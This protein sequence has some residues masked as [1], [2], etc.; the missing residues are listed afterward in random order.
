MIRKNKWLTGTAPDQPWSAAGREALESRCALVWHYLVQAAKPGE[1][2][3]DDVHQL[4][5]WARRAVTAFDAY[6]DLVPRRKGAWLRKQLKRLRRAAGEARDLDVLAERLA[7]GAAKRPASRTLAELD[8][9]RRKARRPIRRLWRRLKRKGY[10]DRVAAVLERL[11]YRG[12]GPEPAFGRGAR[13]SLRRIS[14]QFCRRAAGNLAEPLELHAFRIAGKRL[15]YALELF[16][17]AFG[18]EVRDELYPQVEDLQELLGKIN[19]CA[20]AIERLEG[21]SRSADDAEHRGELVRLV[22]SERSALRRAR[23]RFDNWWTAARRVEIERRLQALRAR[24]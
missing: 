17:G 18:P 9:L 21:W 1:H 4:R 5:V 11:R 13:Q 3:A 10:R 22:A 24:A 6:A 8:E 7:R 2:S 20:S 12:D 14:D 19:D 15:R 16:S 23:R